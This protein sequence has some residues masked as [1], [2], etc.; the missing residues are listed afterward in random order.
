VRAALRTQVRT[1]LAAHLAAT[2]PDLVLSV[3]PLL[4]HVTAALLRD[5]RRRRGLMTV[6]TDL[7]DIHRGWACRE[8]DLIVVPTSEARVAMLHRRVAASR[9]RQLG[10]PVD[11]RFRPARP[12]ERGA[13]RER[14]GLDSRRPTVL[15][16][17]GGEGSGDM[18]GQVGTLAGEPRPWQVIAVCGRNERLRRRLLARSYATPVLALGFVDD[19]PDLMR[20]SDVVIGKAGPGAIAEALATGLPLVLTSYLPGQEHGNV[21]FVVEARVGRY[22]PRPDRLLAAVSELLSGDGEAIR[23]T[24]AHA[25]VLG[26]PRCALDI[27]AACL[28]LVA[29][30]SAVSHASR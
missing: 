27:A 12:G 25:A 4:N 9:I 20:A 24:A 7:V 10:M 15:L 29:D 26:R 8:A 3:H 13:I 22:A 5:G 11:L 2:D 19:M 28:A 6:V 23:A 30:Y 18:L 21:R 16:A 14:L 1:V 17:G